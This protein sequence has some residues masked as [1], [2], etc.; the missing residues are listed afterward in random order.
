[1]KWLLANWQQVWE[2]TVDHL[3]LSLPA[4]LLALLIA[5]PIGRLAFQRPR[6]GGPLL[7]A[8]TLAYAIP[9]LPLLII[10]PALIGTPLRSWQNMVVVLTVYGIALLVRTAADAFASVD[11]TLR[12]AAVAVGY[13]Q[14]GLFWRVDLPLAIPVLISGIRVVTVSTISLVTIGALVGVSSL[15]SLL[16][17][18]FQRGIAA[19]VWTGVVATVILAL[20]LD[21]IVLG[22]GRLLTPWTKRQSSVVEVTSR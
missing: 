9:A 2:L 10:V 6:I 18:G 1:M 7:S 3:M 21:S 15:G 20:L 11:S 13:S 19:E 22:I 16:T 5:I 14:T 12:D 8:A 17:D 4:I